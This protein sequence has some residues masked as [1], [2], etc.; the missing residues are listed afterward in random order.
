M[1]KKKDSGDYFWKM[2]SLASLSVLFVSVFFNAYLVF[3]EGKGIKGNVKVSS[4][5][6]FDE[7]EIY[8]YLTE[9]LP[10]T[11]TI[12][13][14]DNIEK[15]SVFMIP[16]KITFMGREFNEYVIVTNS[17]E[18]IFAPRFIRIPEKSSRPKVE[19]FIM[20]FCPFGRQSMKLMIPVYHALKD[21]I[22]FDVHFVVSKGNDSSCY[23]G[24]CSMHGFNETIEDVRELCIKEIYGIDKLLGYYSCELYKCAYS[25]ITTCWKVC[26]RE[27]G[28]DVE[29]IEKCV[30]EEGGKLLK[31]EYE[32]NEKY[33]V[34]GSPTLVINGVAIESRIEGKHR[35]VNGYKDLICRFFITKPKVCF[36]R[37][38]ESSEGAAPGTC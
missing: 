20:S 2:L 14:G 32:L 16:V 30:E 27:A 33:G 37:L 35:S 15:R 29:R 24:Y 7:G 26:A 34:S 23:E 18:F 36:S 9:M 17:S 8:S 3:V 4:S 5:F 25:N 11:A 28:I 6:S 19:L 1:E 22:D 12:S 21:Y 10:S 31:R 13:F 38:S